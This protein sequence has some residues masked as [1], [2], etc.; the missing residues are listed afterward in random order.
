M[1]DSLSS[2]L[3]RVFKNIRGYGKLNE[4]NIK[5]ALREVR[6]ALLEADVHYQVA[7]D[8]I[9]RVKESCLG[10]DVLESVTP[11]QQVIKHVQDELVHILGDTTADINRSQKPAIVIL[12]GLHGAGKTTTA[13]K[14]ALRWKK[15]GKKVMLGA[16]DIRRPA[17]VDQLAVLAGQ[18][19]VEVVKP[20]KGESVPEVGMRARKK[21]EAEKVD[22]LLLDTGGRFQIDKD[23]VEEVA[24]LRA[25][26]AADNCLLVLDAA[27][28][29]ESVHV[30][31]TFHEKIGL[32]GLILTKLDGDARGGA[33]LSVHS[34]TGCP[35]L[36]VGIGEGMEDIEPFHPDRMASRILGMGDVVTLVEK[37][38]QQVDENEMLRIQKRMESRDF[39]LEDFL[40][41]MQQM[42]K[43]GPLENIMEMLPGGMKLPAA[44]KQQLATDSGGEMKRAQ[45]II[46]SMTPQER[47]TPSI[48]SARRKQRIARGSGMQVQ[49]VNELLKRFKSAKKMTEE[50]KKAQKRLR[51]RMK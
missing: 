48:L 10:A 24:S 42:K 14:L 8:F 31:E 22:I 6:L 44:A 49:H 46:Q 17:A 27:M 37:A 18:V 23:L 30:A 20:D 50:M 4:N 21:A 12:A 5:D 11:G 16:C 9:K 25:Q 29:Q 47:R 7:K 41:Q 35:I 38:Q 34:V 1:F 26:T 33:A 32:T 19:G 2:S 45:A 39:N 15:E 13:G 51:Q 28:G 43:M 3:Q 40:E 36:L